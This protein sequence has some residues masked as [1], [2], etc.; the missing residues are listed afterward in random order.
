RG[1]AGGRDRGDGGT[2]A[3]RE[4]QKNRPRWGGGSRCVPA[5]G[6]GGCGGPQPPRIDSAGL[7]GELGSNQGRETTYTV[8]QIAETEI[9]SGAE[10]P[11]DLGVLNLSLCLRI[12]RWEFE[13]LRPRQ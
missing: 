8:Q 7:R 1:R 13:S 9:C 6:K 10:L 5:F 2:G 3:R 4:H 12:R 11:I